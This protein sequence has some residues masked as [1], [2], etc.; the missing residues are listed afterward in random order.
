M[1]EQKLTISIEYEKPIPL[2]EFST[3]LE[4][5]NNQYKKHSKSEDFLLIKEI[6]QGSIIIDLVPCVMSVIDNL[7]TVCTF[8][9][10]VK[11]VYD[12]LKNKKGDKPSMDIEDCVDVQRTVAPIAHH[13]KSKINIS[14]NGNNNNVYVL[15]S[16]DVKNI[17]DSANEEKLRLESKSVVESNNSYNNVLLRLIQLKYDDKDNK[18]STGIIGDVDKKAHPILFAKGIKN[19]ILHNQKNPFLQGYLVNAKVSKKDEKIV[20]YTITEVMDVCTIEDT[21]SGNKELSLFS[22]SNI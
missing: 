7:G 15:D 16:N 4:S 18:S 3:S 20:S 12:W 22:E 13:E 21:E 19:N 5:W 8:F 2:A 11:T 17:R 9:D 6:R 1:E 10:R 14:I